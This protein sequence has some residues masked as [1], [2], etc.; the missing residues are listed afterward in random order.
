MG[1]KYDNTRIAVVTMPAAE[2]NNDEKGSVFVG[3]ASNS[4]TSYSGKADLRNDTESQLM[5]IF[6]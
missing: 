2:V 5:L 6:I 3:I 1:R 4:N